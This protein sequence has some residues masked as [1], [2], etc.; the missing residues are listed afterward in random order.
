MR[1]PLLGGAFFVRQTCYNKGMKKIIPFIIVLAFIFTAFYIIKTRTLDDVPTIPNVELPSG[2]EQVV[3]VENYIRENIKVLVPELP[4]LG[5]SWY[6]VE[7]NVN[8]HNKNGAVIYEDGH[9]QGAGIFK[10]SL[11]ADGKIIIESFNAVN[12]NDKYIHPTKWPPVV[13]VVDKPFVCDDGNNEY[14]VTALAE[15]A[16]GSTYTEY[17]YT[18]PYGNK[19]ATVNFTI[20]SVQCLNYDE[21]ERNKC[22]EKQGNYDLSPIVDTLFKNFLNN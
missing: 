19:T 20:Q 8:P 17:T 2:I 12:I 18:K 21:P 11:G 13:N 10:Y 15:G 1:T 7:V 6:V 3:L 16:A 5:G 4:V 9:I 22:I 14:C